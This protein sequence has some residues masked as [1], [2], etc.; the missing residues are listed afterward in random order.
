M[1]CARH[2]KPGDADL[3]NRRC[4]FGLPVAG[5]ARGLPGQGRAASVAL[6]GVLL[7]SSP[8]LRPQR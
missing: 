6:A 5:S 7:S 8:L 4:Q 1:W 3:R 2:R